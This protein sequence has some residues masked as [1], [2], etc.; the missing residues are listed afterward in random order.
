MQIIALAFAPVASGQAPYFGVPVSAD[1]LPE[2][3]LRHHFVYPLPDGSAYVITY[4]EDGTTD[5]TLQSGDRFAGTWAIDADGRLCL[6]WAD[7]SEPDCFSA[8]LDGSVLRLV[9]SSGR[10]AGETS[11]PGTAP[12]WLTDPD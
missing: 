7:R 11:L 6:T 12:A 9:D 1:G 4:A 2:I 5:L 10:I 3:L 8:F